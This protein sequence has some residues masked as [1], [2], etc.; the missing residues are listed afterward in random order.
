MSSDSRSKV[1]ALHLKRNA[2]VY[3]RQS[4]PRQVL[5]NVESSKRQYDL[6]QHVIALG[7][8]IDQVISIDKDQGQSGKFSSDREGFQHLVAEVSLERAGIVMGLETT[9]PPT[10]DRSEHPFFRTLNCSRRADAKRKS[11]YSPSNAT[12]KRFGTWGACQQ[13]AGARSAPDLLPAPPDR[14]LDGRGSD[15]TYGAYHQPRLTTALNGPRH[16][17]PG[18]YSTLPI[19]TKL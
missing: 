14:Q 15:D 10:P 7:W 16:N 18:K 5:E 9:A 1:Q 2:H 11:V 13:G 19:F 17:R 6:R 12:D 3:I 8:S 4:S